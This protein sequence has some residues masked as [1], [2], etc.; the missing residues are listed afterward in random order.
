MIDFKRITHH[1][2][3][4]NA[5][6]LWL[7]QIAN[8]VIPII[9]IPY[10]TR[11]LGVERFGE[12]CYAQNIL[13]YMA[14]LI[15]F[16]FDYCATQDIANHRE[17]KQAVQAIFSMVMSCKFVLFIVTL[18]LLLVL[19][20]ILAPVHSDPIL[21]IWACLFNL[22]FVLFPTWFYQGQEEMQKMS[23]LNFLSK[24]LG[25]VAI[26]CFVKSEQHASIYLAILAITSII[27]GLISLKWTP[28]YSLHGALKHPL[29]LQVLRKSI[30]VFITNVANSLYS[31]IG[32]TIIGMLLSTH[33][34]GIYAGSQKIVQ[35]CIML[36]TM[37]FIVALFPRVSRAFHENRALGWGLFRKII[38]IAITMG[39]FLTIIIYVS[40]PLLV[41]ILLGDAFISS[42][43][44][45]R[46][47]AGIPAMVLLCTVLTV[48]GLYGLQ[49]QRFT[50]WI[51]LLSGA[52]S[53]IINLHLIP[54]IHAV[55]SILA[56]YVAQFIEAIIAGLIVW[57]Y[58]SIDK[59]N[60]Q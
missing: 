28:T 50:P 14:I 19:Y 15:N 21:Y 22:S 17:D 27:I 7:V 30:P 18:L 29:A 36:T 49:L 3:V 51:A 55:G 54:I 11:I 37:P 9:V 34:V 59:I 4:K 33:D 2:L 43:E 26:F 44:Q 39:V 25:A 52:I 20:F 31:S 42:V 56:W 32:L 5:M 8:Y 41:R 57:R 45:I 1:R 10:V 12:V 48:Q 60:L 6:A 35:A 47:M 58:Y 24:F 16:G 38:L 40:A 13:S 46:T 23:L 53:V